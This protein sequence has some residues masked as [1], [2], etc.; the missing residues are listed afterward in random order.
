MMTFIIVVI[1][2]VILFALDNE[3][4]FGGRRRLDWLRS[5]L[6]WATKS[7]GGVVI[8]IVTIGFILWSLSYL[9]AAYSGH[10]TASSQVIFFFLLTLFVGWKRSWNWRKLAIV[11]V[12]VTVVAFLL[13]YY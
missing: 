3:G 12:I 8:F 10:V 9:V 11:T 13:T 4:K 1:I 7:I 5:F 2:V 6:Q